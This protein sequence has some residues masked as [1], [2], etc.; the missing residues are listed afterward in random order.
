LYCI[1]RRFG[2]Q[3]ARVKGVHANPICKFLDR[4]ADAAYDADT[5]KK[6]MM[7]TFCSGIRQEKK[8]KDTIN[9]LQSDGYREI[10]INGHLKNKNK[11]S[12]TKSVSYHNCFSKTTK[13]S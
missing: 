10:I 11:Q 1:I 4:N 8:E 6:Y 13:Q 3:S 7:M 9:Y 2:A 5:S 12:M